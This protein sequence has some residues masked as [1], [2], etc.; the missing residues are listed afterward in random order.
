M[1]G[2]FDFIYCLRHYLKMPLEHFL[3]NNKNGRRE[4]NHDNKYQIIKRSNNN[5]G[6]HYDDINR[7]EKLSIT[8][9]QYHTS[10][11]LVEHS[12]NG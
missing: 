1:R 8:I 3:M 9:L 10:K 7:K 11:N 12:L 4:K 5:D 2:K 6:K